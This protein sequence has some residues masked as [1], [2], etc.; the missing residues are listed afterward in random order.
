MSKGELNFLEFFQSFR[1]GELLHSTNER[2]EEVMRAVCETGQKGEITI[3]L[4]VK[5]NE[6]GQIECK[7]SISVKKPYPALGTG[8]YYATADGKL[9]RRDPN[10]ADMF[11]GEG[12]AFASRRSE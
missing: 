6:A 1:R 11:D 7:P 10:Q 4:P 12:A 8:I 2:W 9:T 3:K 5:V